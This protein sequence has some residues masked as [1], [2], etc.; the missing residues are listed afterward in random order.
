MSVQAAKFRAIAGELQHLLP[1]NDDSIFNFYRNLEHSENPFIVIPLTF[2]KQ[3]KETA[4]ADFTCLASPCNVAWHALDRV[5][6]RRSRLEWDAVSIN[7]SRTYS[8]AEA[9]EIL[10]GL[11]KFRPLAAIEHCSP[12]QAFDYFGR[13]LASLNRSTDG[14]LRESFNNTKNELAERLSLSHY[15]VNWPLGGPGLLECASVKLQ[16]LKIL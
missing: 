12:R 3:G 10:T 13:T 6:A 1:H 2:Y 15:A 11:F 5:L 8:R 4:K 9:E 16:G 7:H 14:T